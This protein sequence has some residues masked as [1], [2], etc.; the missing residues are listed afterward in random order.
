MAEIAYFVPGSSPAHIDSSEQPSPLQVYLPAMPAGVAAAY[1]EAYTQPGDLVLDMFCQ[2]PQV[3]RE[4]LALG[5]RVLATNLNPVA[6]CAVELGLAWNNWPDRQA[7]SAAFTHLLSSSKDSAHSPLDTR[8]A[9]HYTSRCPTCRKP[10][11]ALSFVWDRDRGEA[12]EKRVQCVQCQAE[13]SGPSDAEDMAL[14]KR[15]EPRSLPYWLLLERVTTPDMAE[16]SDERERAAAVLAAYTPRALAAISDILIR[17]DALPESERALLRPLLLETLAECSM[18][19]P[20]TERGQPARPRSLKAPATFVER[21][22]LNS[23]EKRFKRWMGQAAEQSLTRAK[24]LEALLAGR[25]PAGYLVARSS[26]EIAQVV[27][28]D[29]VALAVGLAPELNST[30]WAL[31]AVWSAWL[32]GKDTADVLRPLLSHRRADTEWLW[33]ALAPSLQAVASRLSEP[34]KLVLIH[35][36]A[37]DESLG[38]LAL[39]GAGAKLTLAHALAEPHDGLRMTWRR[40]A[41]M[42]ERQLDI[43]ALGIEVMEVT[44]QAALDILRARSEPSTW[45]HLAAGIYR[46]LARTDLLTI[47]TRLPD[48]NPPPLALLTHFVR[49]TFEGR[50]TALQRVEGSDQVWW[51]NRSIGGG[52]E[53]PLSDL[54]ELAVYDVLQQ[55]TE[56][57]EAALLRAI[58]AQFPGNL[59][60]ERSLVT[61]CLESYAQ[62]V[63]PGV[64]SLREED[65]PTPRRQEIEGL[66]HQ[67]EVIGKRIGWEVGEHANNRL[68]WSEK[69]T[70]AYT[71]VFS[72]T[73]QLAPHLLTK[74]PPLGTP[75][76]VIPG[77]RAGLIEYKLRRNVQFRNAAAGAGWQ[78]LKFGPPL[79]HIDGDHLAAI[80]EH[81]DASV[82]Q[83]L[84][85]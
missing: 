63:S 38:A 34:G 56:W 29:Q 19:H 60:P 20:H 26:R 80:H 82:Q 36:D 3:I 15:Y 30:F 13:S 45:P 52:M 32:W 55:A 4:G 37:N 16:H 18:L 41:V 6:I 49:G 44:E 50:E 64:Y 39:A 74:R 33:R 77:G 17:L 43:E 83:P 54:V 70:P 51:T 65:H 69:H 58:Y 53:V 8:L 47:T 78:F 68:V 25:E 59:T 5:R 40:G 76:L 2:T 24:Q 28:T 14:A 79:C 62:S 67:L 48:V 57:E 61:L 72:A 84:P 81:D 73:A 9:A 22:V 21:S 35:R 12:I 85:H 42:P 10:A 46:A 66:R 75:V 71:F 11:R 23:L 27:E 31:G 1:I 7:V